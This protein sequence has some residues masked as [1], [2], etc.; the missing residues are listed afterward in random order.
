MF[1]YPNGVRILRFL[2]D[3]LAKSENEAEKIHL[4][5][6]IRVLIFL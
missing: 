3:G 2:R 1:I 4:I 5:R 6:V